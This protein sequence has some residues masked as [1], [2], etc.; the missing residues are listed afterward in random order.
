M[1][2]MLVLEVASATRPGFLGPLNGINAF[3]RRTGLRPEY[4][5]YQGVILMRKVA[6]T[7]FIA[8]NQLGPMFEK[9]E[10]TVREQGE[11]GL[12]QQLDRIDAMASAVDNETV[13][14]LRL[15]MVPFVKDTETF[16]KGIRGF[17]EANTVRNDREV[18]AAIVEV[19]RKRREAGD[20]QGQA[21]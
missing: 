4:L 15:E 9:P 19:I 5:P 6:F 20:V 1:T 13:K 3:V 18:Q 2:A 10:D 21:G 12:M 7:F 11:K 8:M 14:L 17:L 16:K